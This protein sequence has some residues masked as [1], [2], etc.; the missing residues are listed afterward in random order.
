MESHKIA[1]I[2]GSSC[3]GKIPYESIIIDPDPIDIFPDDFI[4]PGVEVSK[5]QI[6][7]IEVDWSLCPSGAQFTREL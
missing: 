3:D 1:H 5:S 7:E 6:I 2:I 4:P